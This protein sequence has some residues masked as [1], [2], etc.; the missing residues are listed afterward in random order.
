M[1]TTTAGLKSPGPTPPTPPHAVSGRKIPRSAPA[2]WSNWVSKAMRYT[3]SK[4]ATLMPSSAG[5]SIVLARTEHSGSAGTRPPRTTPDDADSG[6][7]TSSGE[8]ENASTATENPRNSSYQ[9]FLKWSSW[10]AFATICGFI[11]NAA[12]IHPT[13]ESAR[14]ARESI[15]IDQWTALKDYKDYCQNILVSLHSALL[16]SMI[17]IRSSHRTPQIILLLNAVRR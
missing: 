7:L 6:S 9:V 16:R 1:P 15:D 10:A 3:V 11:I 17:L 4:A 5:P 8:S 2:P 14:L 12:I 13:F